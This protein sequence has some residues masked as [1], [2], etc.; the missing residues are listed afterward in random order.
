MASG[1]GVKALFWEELGLKSLSLT[2]VY[3]PKEIA[4]IA[5][6]CNDGVL[7]W[8]VM[9]DRKPKPRRPQRRW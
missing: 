9:T 8:C 7:Q 4:V 1:V 6:T 2:H 3:D 5:P